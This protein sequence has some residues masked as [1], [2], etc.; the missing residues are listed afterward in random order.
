MCMTTLF[1]M[2]KSSVV[3]IIHVLIGII[4]DVAVSGSDLSD[5]SEE[6]EMDNYNSAGEEIEED[7]FDDSQ[8]D[9]SPKDDMELE[10]DV[11]DDSLEGE[12]ERGVHLH[13]CMYF[14]QFLS[15]SMV[16]NFPQP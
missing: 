16:L 5:G 3:F 9:F 10:D 6:E 7:D 12:R 1:P 14:H 4:S 11:P 13:T 8:N 2:G 15:Y